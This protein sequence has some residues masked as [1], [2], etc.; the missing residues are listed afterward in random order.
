M[1]E[2][3]KA[4]TNALTAE[5]STTP[6]HYFQV[7]FLTGFQRELMEEERKLRDEISDIQSLLLPHLEVMQHHVKIYK[8]IIVSLSLSSIKHMT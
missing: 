7:R 5:P 1:S 4:N 8:E 6:V 3:T 2:D